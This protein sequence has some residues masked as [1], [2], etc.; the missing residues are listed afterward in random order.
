MSFV[1]LTEYYRKSNHHLY[2]A[3]EIETLEN[4]EVNWLKTVYLFA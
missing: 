3:I 1:F 2:W 4:K